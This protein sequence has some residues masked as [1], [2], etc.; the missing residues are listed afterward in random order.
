MAS[1]GS[2]SLSVVQVRK[3]GSAKVRD[4]VTDTLESRF[5]GVQAIDTVSINGR[6]LVL[7]GGADDGVSV[8]EL[9]PDGRLMLLTSVSDGWGTTLSDI[10]AIAAHLVGNEVQVFVTGAE[11]GITQFTLD[12]GNFGALRTGSKRPNDIHGGAGDDLILGR[13]GMDVLHGGRGDDRLVDGP[14]FDVLTGGPGDDIFSFRP[15]GRLDKVTDFTLGHDR[16]DLSA[17]D[18]LYSMDQ[19]SITP[20]GYGF[21]IRFRDEKFRIETDDHHK[22]LPHDLTPDHFIF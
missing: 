10:T 12:L 17:F 1:A 13:G 8:F 22:L 15:D 3:N 21:M 2:D 6:C 18:R 4:H 9:A 14:G 20:K 19:L 16:I 7:A 5:E 11:S